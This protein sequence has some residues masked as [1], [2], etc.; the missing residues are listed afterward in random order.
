MDFKKVQPDSEAPVKATRE[1]NFS[2]PSALL[3][4]MHEPKAKGLD[5]GEM[6]RTVKGVENKRCALVQLFSIRQLDQAKTF[7]ILKNNSVHF[8]TNHTELTAKFGH[9]NHVEL[10]ESFLKEAHRA[11]S[12]IAARKPAFKLVLAQGRLA[13]GDGIR[14]S[15]S[16]VRRR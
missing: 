14:C 1:V 2:F 7:Q 3:E 13:G 5:R 4:V 11:H 10:V 16:V 8:L 6:M 15:G 12:D 9:L